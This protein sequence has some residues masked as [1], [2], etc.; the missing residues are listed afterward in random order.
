MKREIFA[1]QLHYPV[2]FPVTEKLSVSIPS[3]CF[4]CSCK[5]IKDSSS[6]R[7]DAMR[8]FYSLLANCQNKYRRPG[9]KTEKVA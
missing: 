3:E 2:T 4:F 8:H 1:L 6:Y 7:T 5:T 9:A